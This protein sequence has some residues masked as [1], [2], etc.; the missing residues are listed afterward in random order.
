MTVERTGWMDKDPQRIGLALSGGGFRATLF[1]LGVVRLL[2]ET[3]QLSAVKRVGA[4]SRGSIL[5]AHLVLNWDQYVGSDHQFDSAAQEI[6]QFVRRDI[7]GRIVRSWI[8]AWLTLLPRLLMPRARR[9][10]FTNLLEGYYASLYRRAR[11][12]DLYGPRES[13]RP[14]VFFYCASLTSGALCSFSRS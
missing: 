1:H 9:W 12:K 6:I 5:A 11:L 3:K 8:L 4:V 13:E 7:R 10:T 14:E 2:Y